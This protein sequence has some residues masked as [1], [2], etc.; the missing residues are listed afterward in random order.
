MD[1][2]TLAVAFWFALAAVLVA[3]VLLVRQRRI[4]A[5]LREQA[6]GAQAVTDAWAAEEAH[7]VNARIPAL[8][9]SL[10][11][12]PVEVPGPVNPR[13][14]QSHGRVLDLFADSVQQATA[15]GE[16]SAKATLKSMM[17]AVQSL[18][19]EQQVAISA[20]QERHDDAD[21]LQG[22][23]RIDHM[24]SQL[25]RRAQATAVLCGS[26]PGQQRSA[27][28][29]TDVVRGATSRIRDYLRVNI[30]IEAD[31][32]V[33]S[34][35]VEP[36]VLAVAELLDNGA[37]HSQPNT[38]VEVNFQQ[39]HNGIAIM[40]D[41][42]GVGMTAEEL[43]RAARLLAGDG[44]SDISRLGDPPQVGFAVIGVLAA[45]YGFRVSVDTRSPYG[46]VRA[47][48]FLP[49]ELLTRV[50]KPLPTPAAPAPTPVP[51][52]PAP[53]AAPEAEQKRTP[54]GLPKRKRREPAGE[55]AAAPS[56]PPGS[57]G[58]ARP[59]EQIA[60]GLGAWQRGTRSGRTASPTA[61]EGNPQA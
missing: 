6:T 16:Q 1:Q 36:V 15:R 7:L 30:P 57:P 27:S 17:R 3:V 18:A 32:A 10:S 5:D 58:A 23:L 37:R 59:S 28:S 56:A 51:A 40:V 24:N 43:G 41:D 13:F 48:V 26:W 47:V 22:L 42:A 11:N 14:A 34:R 54:G 39:A 60:A 21:V 52:A 4:T 49:T 33:T 35:A 19:N 38:A 44:A 53:A 45:R 46:G 12:R 8:A 29:L 61:A 20:M 25:G 31:I 2:Q 9:E 55:Q 50:D